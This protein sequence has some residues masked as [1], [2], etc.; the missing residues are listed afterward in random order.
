MESECR[1]EQRPEP[2]RSI[3]HPKRIIPHGFV[4]GELPF[5]VH[6][7]IVVLRWFGTAIHLQTV[8][9]R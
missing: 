8:L 2:E 3:E 7:G 9:L 5:D 1:A 4:T 6:I